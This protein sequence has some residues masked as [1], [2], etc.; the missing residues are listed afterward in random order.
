MPPLSKSWPNVE[1]VHMKDGRLLDFFGKT[2]MQKDSYITSDGDICVRLSLSD[3]EV[4]TLKLRADMIPMYAGWGAE[5]RLEREIV[6]IKDIDDAVTAI[7]A[8]M[9]RLNESKWG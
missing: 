9:A 8:L 7:D 6:G 3:G 4:R 1:T 5:R 2:R